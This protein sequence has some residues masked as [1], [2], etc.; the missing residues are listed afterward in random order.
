VPVAGALALTVAGLIVAPRKWMWY[1]EVLTYLLVTD[2]SW[3]HMM[4]AIAG[5]AE[6][7]PPLY[8]VLARGWAAAFGAAPLSLRL[9]T[10][11]G[12]GAALLLLWR[13]LT[14]AFP[15][16]VAAVALLALACGSELFFLQVAEVRYYGLLT[17][18]VAL[19]MLLSH[20]VMLADRPPLGLLVA[21][22]ATQ[23]ALVLAHVYGGLYGAA[24]LLAVVL[25]DLGRGR[26][27][28]RRWAAYPLGWL[29]LVPWLGV[30]Q[31]QRASA[32]RSWMPAPTLGELARGYRFEAASEVVP[33]AL[34]T[35]ALL[36]AATAALRERPP[37][38]PAPP[39]SR[40]GPAPPGARGAL[41]LVA[42]ALLTVPVMA[43]IVSHLVVPVFHPRYLIG[44]ALACPVVVAYVLTLVLEASP[45]H[46]APPAAF[47]RVARPVVAVGWVAVCGALLAFPV[48][49]A[50][51][52]RGTVRPGTD[53]ERLRADLR[54]DGAP[55][56][57]L[58]VAVESAFDYLPLMAHS[59]T[60]GAYTFVLDSAVAL[61]SASHHRE[62]LGY[63]LLRVYRSVGY[64]RGQLVDVERFVCAHPRFLV[65][66]ARETHWY[67]LRVAPD[68]A[69]ASTVVGRT[70]HTSTTPGA[71]VRLV[72][73]VPG[74]VPAHCGAGRPAGAARDT[75]AARWTL[76]YL[77]APPTRS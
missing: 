5:G 38:P 68:P 28:V 56:A 3:R 47:R 12:L 53:V 71:V 4:A 58:P 24:L 51:A 15:R 37:A 39:A 62:L 34:V 23:A 30:Y 48:L 29:A 72:R 40:A 50:R 60:P 32:H 70:D 42:G 13:A 44:A 64:T 61:D 26:V 25:W 74:R 9:F 35:A 31:A 33:F 59:P 21:T 76:D 69:F 66:D 57:A 55:A 6:A 7:A 11:A 63:T 43:A 20:R 8:H 14:P 1:D 19:G 54:V 17:A 22:A 65:L 36:A 77:S 52:F 10:D 18:L 45:A 67:D 41:L 46:G 73:R 16:R 49:R 2:P 75:T 27:D